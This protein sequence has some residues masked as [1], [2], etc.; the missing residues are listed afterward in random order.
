MS[1]TKKIL[2]AIDFSEY[3]KM[4]L[5]HAAFLAKDLEAELAIV[6]IINQRD[7][8]VMDSSINRVKVFH[9]I[10]DIST[11]LDQVKEERKKEFAQLEKSVDLTNISYSLSFREGVPVEELLKFAKEENVQMVVM[12]VKG[13]T[14]LADFLVGSTASKMFRICPVPLVTVRESASF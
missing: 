11:W 4:T 10:M 12:G 13:R 3:S 5:Q 9:Q 8:D 7:I 6:N 14:D 1:K 2:A